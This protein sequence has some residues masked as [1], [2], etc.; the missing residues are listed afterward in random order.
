MDETT[1]IML[2]DAYEET[3]HESYAMGCNPEVAHREGVIAAAMFLSSMTGLED[4][5][6]R[7]EVEK[8]NLK[9]N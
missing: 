4:V 1:K 2:A 5:A 3:I 9:A 6:A 7:R 8:L